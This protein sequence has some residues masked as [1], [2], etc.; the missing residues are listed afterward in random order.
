MAYFVRLTR[1]GKRISERKP[2]TS[3]A[4]KTS[5]YPSRLGWYS[6]IE[7]LTESQY[8]HLILVDLKLLIIAIFVILTSLH[9]GSD[10]RVLPDVRKYMQLGK[11]QNQE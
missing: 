8:G 9:I 4:S 2:N 10:H 5:R 1:S 7:R 6:T 3:I 11:L